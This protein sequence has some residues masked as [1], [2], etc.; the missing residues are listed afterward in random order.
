MKYIP[1]PLQDASSQT[2]G[3]SLGINLTNDTQ[4][5]VTT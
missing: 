5:R 3:Y 2:C 1:K 4:Q